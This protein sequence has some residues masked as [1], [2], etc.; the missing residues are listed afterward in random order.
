VIA[1]VSDLDE[2]TGDRPV[3]E[4]DCGELRLTET[5]VV[6]ESCARQTDALR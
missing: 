5:L 6:A 3:A 4:G 2:R 1:F